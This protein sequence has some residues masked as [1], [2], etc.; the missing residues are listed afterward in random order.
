MLSN[1]ISGANGTSDACHANEP[2]GAVNFLPAG[3]LQIKKTMQELMSDISTRIAING[4]DEHARKGAIDDLR[5][6]GLNETQIAARLLRCKAGETQRGNLHRAL[7]M[8]GW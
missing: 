5:K 3:S 2:E 4:Q 1:R 7:Q 6:S 8:V